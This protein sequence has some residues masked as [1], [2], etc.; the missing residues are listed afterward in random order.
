MVLRLFVSLL[1]ALLGSAGLAA[2]DPVFPPGQRIGLVPPPGLT[3]STR[4][5]GFEDT[6]RKV[7][8]TILDLPPRAYNEMLSTLFGQSPPAVTV[9][10]REMF[11]FNSGFGNLVT[12]RAVANGVAV[13]RW[14]LLASTSNATVG[15]LATLVNVEVPDAALATYPDAAIRAALATVTFRPAPLAERLKLLPFKLDAMADFRVI[16]VMPAGVVLVDGPEND[17]RNHGYMVVEVGQGSPSEPDARARFARDVLMRAPVGDL[18][19]TSAEPMRIGNWPGFEIRAQAKQ[20]DG[21]PIALVQWLRFGS[22][23]FA[24]I[25]GVAPKDEWDRLFPRFRAVRDGVDQR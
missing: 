23:G 7:V 1:A 2:A 16:E 8:I 3:L 20:P 15:H 5:P 12:A 14:L 18:A 17:L 21:T 4:F 25:V 10:K 19:I 9:E 24:R 13:H 22:G 6:D 11:A